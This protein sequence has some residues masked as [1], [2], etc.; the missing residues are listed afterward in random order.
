MRLKTWK[1]GWY[2]KVVLT[3]TA[4]SIVGLLVRELPKSVEAKAERENKAPYV[5]FIG[6]RERDIDEAMDWTV[7]GVTATRLKDASRYERVNAILRS[8]YA[9]P[10]KF[11]VKFATDD[12]IILESESK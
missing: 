5:Y 10:E 4:V 8:L 12:F 1:V 9:R 7:A 11:R 2:G 6:L 3:I